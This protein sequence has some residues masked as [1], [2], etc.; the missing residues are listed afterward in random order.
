ML[1]H[2]DLEKIWRGKRGMRTGI[3]ACAQAKCVVSALTLIYSAIDAMASLTRVG[4]DAR[5]TRKEFLAW[6]EE[7]LLPQLDG[8]LTSLDLYGARCGVVHTYGPDSNLSRTGQARILIY[9]WRHGHRPD[10]PLLEERSRSATVIEIECLIEGL[11]R[12]VDQFK[13]RVA[14]DPELRER[15]ESNVGDLLCYE[16]WHP[17]TVTIAA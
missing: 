12:A 1:S 5:G 10:D 2:P 11:E 7:Y 3:R 8:S 9:K 14:E 16:P 15:V 6:A 17:V 13:A 4:R